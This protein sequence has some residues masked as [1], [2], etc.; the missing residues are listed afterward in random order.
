MGNSVG[1]Q[2]G[3]SILNQI[4][5]SHGGVAAE[6]PAN[7]QVTAANIAELNAVLNAPASYNVPISGG[8][9]S[10]G[11]FIGGYDALQ[12]YGNS[13][14]SKAKEKLIRDIAEEVFNVLKVPGAKNA[15]SAPISDIVAHLKKLSPNPKKGKKFNE[16]F[17]S[18]SSK[19]K[20]VCHA[21]ANAIN[22]NYGGSVI[23][24]NSNEKEMCN[25]VGEVMYSL[26]TG[27]HT[28]FMNVAGDVMRIIRNMRTV[29]DA[30]DAAYRKQIALIQSAGDSQLK[31]QSDNTTSLYKEL[32]DE[33]DRQ[34]AVLAN[35]MNVSIGP[36]GQSLISSLED[37]KDFAGLI[38]DIGAEPG[39][40]A[41]GEKLAHLLSGVSSIAHSAELIDKALKKIGMSVGEFK[42]AKDASEL[43]IKTIGHI[44][45]K[46]PSSKQLDEMMAAA[47][48]IYT[49]NYDHDAVSKLLKGGES[50][51]GG[52][53]ES[54]DEPVQGG[55][56]ED[57]DNNMTPYWSKKSLS[58]KISNKKK[59]RDLVL[60][61][62]RKL[63]RGYYQ[64]VVEAANHI[65][66]KI[67]NEIQLSDDLDNFVKAF[68]NLPTLD[69][70]KIHIALSGYAQDVRSKEKREQF[71]NDYKLVVDC[72]Q[73]L[74]K[75]PAGAS[76][77]EIQL[78]I[79]QMLRAIDD[80]SD[81]MVKAI[82]EIHV[83]RPDQIQ[84]EIKKTATIYGSAEHD[85][86]FGTGSWVAFDKVKME[87]KHFH[88]IADI[89]TNMSRMASEVNDYGVEY[90]Q[91]L[92][93]E[94][95][96]LINNIKSE[97][98]AL[99]DELNLDGD[100]AAALPAL[101]NPSP[102]QIRARAIRTTF[103]TNAAGTTNEQKQASR[104]MLKNILT[105]QMN[106]KV[107]M[108]KV[109]QAVDLYL[110]AVT[111]GL[112]KNPDSV[113][114]VVKLL[115]QVDIVAR[116]FNDK[117]GD[118]L[119]TLFECFPNAADGA[120]R[121]YSADVLTA[122]AKEVKMP[123][124]NQ[125]NHY[126]QDME[127][128]WNAAREN[129]PGNPFIGRK[130]ADTTEA[131]MTSMLNLSEK[132]VK[133]MRALENI[134]SAFSSVGAKLGD[135]N[136]AAMTFMNPGQIFNHLCNYI[137]M[138]AF[139]TQ[140]AP[141]VITKDA[142]NAPVVNDT[143]TAAVY[144]G[145]VDQQ[146]ITVSTDGVAVASTI[147]TTN[148]MA[149]YRQ[150][151]V[152][153]G[154][155][156]LTSSR[157][158]SELQSLH[159]S[160]LTEVGTEHDEEVSFGIIT[161]V[162]NVVN[163]DVNLKTTCI[164]MAAIPAD[165]EYTSSTRTKSNY[166][167]Y[168]DYTNNREVARIDR[169]GWADMFYDTDLLFEMTIKSIVAKV[170]T[171]VDAYR[172]FHRPTVGRSHVYSLNPLR[173]IIGGSEANGGSLSTTVKVVPEALE[174]YF[175]LPLLAEWYREMFG[176]KNNTPNNSDVP[177]LN[178]VNK[179]WKLSIVPSIDG[180]WSEFVNTVFDQAVFVTEG[181]YTESQIQ[182]M[183]EE[184]NKIYKVYKAKY[185][186]ATVRNIINA[187][188]LE[189]NRIF[190]F[191][192][193]EEIKAYLDDKRSYLTQ[194]LGD[195]KEN[196]IDYDILDANDQFG[197]RPAPSDKF[198]NVGLNSRRN[199]ANKER[200]YM[201]QYVH[202]LRTSMD[203]QFMKYT[204]D[205]T[206]TTFS[207]VDTLKN[208]KKDI[209]SARSSEEEYRVV[210]NM[211]QGANKQIHVGY[212]RLIMVHETVAAPLAVLYSIYKVLAKYNALVHS[213]SLNNIDKW[214]NLRQTLGANNPV[215]LGMATTKQ[216]R[217][218][219]RAYL[220]ATYTK[221]I[222]KNQFNLFTLLL[223]GGLPDATPLNPHIGGY[224]N[225]TVGAGVKIT[226]SL[227]SG[228]DILQD[229][230]SA[231]LD[232][233]TTDSN[234]VG[235]SV[236]S[237]GNINIDYSKLQELSVSLLEQVKSNI[238]KLRPLFTG[239]TEAVDKYEDSTTVGST[240]WLEE[241]LVQFLFNNRDEAGLES[242]L[243]NH[244]HKTIEKL[245][246]PPT[247]G[248]VA[249]TDTSY[250][251]MDNAFRGL[252][253][254][255]YLAGAN[256]LVN[257][258]V[259]NNT[260]DFPFNAIAFTKTPE[261]DLEKKTISEAASGS[262]LTAAGGVDIFN[263]LTTVPLIAFETA[264]SINTFN[265]EVNVNKSLMVTLNKLAHMYM[266]T[267]FDNGPAKFYTPLI[268][269]FA[270]SAGSK[271]VIQ[272]KAVPNTTPR[273]DIN[274]THN[275]NNPFAYGNPL[276]SPPEG[277]ILFSSVAATMRSL[278][279]STQLV[280]TVQKKKFAYETLAEVPDYVKDRMKVNLPLFIKMFQNY[281]N[282]AELLKKLLNY[283]GLKN[284]IHSCVTGIVAMPPV[285][286]IAPPGVALPLPAAG[287]TVGLRPFQNGAA[288]NAFYN[289][290]VDHSNVTSARNLVY[291]NGMLDR[292]IEC[293]ASLRKN[294]E[295]VYKELND[296]PPYFLETSK[297][298][299]TD[300][301]QRTGKLPIMP[302]SSLLAVLRVREGVPTAW[303]TV[304]E[305][306]L[307]LPVVENGSDVYKFNYGTRILLA[308]NDIE[309][310][311]EQMPGAKEVY[312]NYASKE[313]TNA[314][315]SMQ[316]YTNTIKNMVKLVRF[317]ADGASY[318]R[319]FDRHDVAAVNAAG[320]QYRTPGIFNA[321][322]WT[323]TT[324]GPV[325]GAN[326]HTSNAAA[327]SAL[328]DAR[329]RDGTN[330]DNYQNLH[331]NLSVFSLRSEGN[332]KATIDLT[333]N[334]SL[335]SNKENFARTLGVLTA[336]TKNNERD[337]LRVYNILDM[338]V[339]PINVHAFM[340]EIP[341]VNILNYAYTFDRMVH[342]FI[343][344]SY[345]ANLTKE[346]TELTTE[347]IMIKADSPVFST[348]EMLV[349]L[350]CHP[351]ADLGTDGRQYFALVASLFNGNDAMKLGRPR[352]LSDQLWHKVFLTS[353][354]QLVANQ[355]VF[356]EGLNRYDTDM[357]SLEAG[358]TAYEAVRAAIRYS[359][360]NMTTNDATYAHQENK[361]ESIADVMLAAGN[362]YVAGNHFHVLSGILF[363]ISSV[364]AAR[365][366]LNANIGTITVAEA[367]VAL[368]SAALGHSFT[369]ATNA[370][371]TPA[372][373]IASL[374][375][376]ATAVAGGAAAAGLGLTLEQAGAIIDY[377]TAVNAHA[378]IV[379]DIRNTITTDVA[380]P[381]A[382]SAQLN[383]VLAADSK[384]HEDT[385]QLV[386][387]ILSNTAINGVAI[388][389]ASQKIINTIMP[390]YAENNKITG[391]AAGLGGRASKG[392]FHER[393]DE[394]TESLEGTK[395]LSLALV[396]LSTTTN[397][398][399]AGPPSAAAIAVVAATNTAKNVAAIAG[400]GS[401]VSN[402]ILALALDPAVVAVPNNYFKNSGSVFAGGKLYRNLKNELTRAV[403]HQLT[404]AA[405]VLAA[406]GRLAYGNADRNAQVNK[407]VDSAIQHL[408]STPASTA[409]QLEAA[410][411]RVNIPGAPAE[412]IADINNCAT[413]A[414][415]TA[416]EVARANMY[417][418]TVNR[419]IEEFAR[420]TGL[421]SDISDGKAQASFKESLL[422]ALSSGVYYDPMVTQPAEDGAANGTAG[423]L[424]EFK[425]AIVTP[426]EGLLAA[427]SEASLRSP[428]S[429]HDVNNR[430]AQLML[431]SRTNATNTIAAL[432]FDRPGKNGIAAYISGMIRLYTSTTKSL[433]GNLENLNKSTEFKVLRK[434]APLNI[435]SGPVSTMGLKY[436]D[437]NNKTWSVRAGGAANMD[438]GDVLYC[439]ELGKMRFDTKLVRNLTWLVQLQR[440]MRVVLINHLSWINTPVIRG[441][442]IADPKVTEYAG[443]DQFDEKD[444]TGEN[445]SMF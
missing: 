96:W 344:P 217:D 138:S 19:Q 413:V 26:F 136:P 436:W 399:L 308:R 15:R 65:S 51:R 36:T 188:I 269:T 151:S 212:D 10:G 109:A 44:M 56:D 207:F 387:R 156:G 421:N 408:T 433:A 265:I 12:D 134:L 35:L 9:V 146:R 425:N 178:S 345:I 209:A 304:D 227:V 383:A 401:E 245:S 153:G 86:T 271:E 202:Q 84:A 277:S 94:S 49:N 229:I 366:A 294:A 322:Q 25:Q 377:N 118:N 11:S 162:S 427:H 123:P 181:N 110:K 106:A 1:S 220:E 236:G 117:S 246:V 360:T 411:A 228:V 328:P 352:Y 122:E 80:F 420:V 219:Y 20:E 426:N 356:R 163:A 396:A 140:F 169:A 422:L 440:I 92:G 382:V 282:R 232:L 397:G 370:I 390:A 243:T 27:L 306:H 222:D 429:T 273:I 218:V 398:A 69:E 423:S 337:K 261:T 40:S 394:I 443:N 73:P 428:I 354:A 143:I 239:N 93:E 367:P 332:L 255:R 348:R 323:H 131:G 128:K 419:L 335:D 338:N 28:E 184:M 127:S 307:L 257:N 66:H 176:I 166:W 90:E 329:K 187:Y 174:L 77:K 5:L 182:R 327:L 235:C 61:D 434:N 424:G 358:P 415:T 363:A 290:L 309:P 244:L 116:W 295:A 59:Y 437:H 206:D 103:T 371:N 305:S 192:K 376:D 191:L 21:L 435:P 410:M 208:Y 97:Y 407:W 317:L 254:Y 3:G 272:G 173:T 33:Y 102:L 250:G 83:D 147:P 234:L 99:I 216:L 318:G 154:L 172:L 362:A 346:G 183:I 302:A 368:I 120:N 148:Q 108:V 242:A 58:K 38:K 373:I 17:N 324:I 287:G 160:G 101:A 293:S 18:S 55:D 412:V 205:D 230:L 159:L 379:Q 89:K 201:Q 313:G 57:F 82:T 315:V 157:R 384:S 319:L 195:D 63:L 260:R 167:K 76:F 296:K 144:K 361:N 439:A 388:P 442:K 350:L 189:M 23:N 107:N 403:Q 193:T 34:S 42:N 341:F 30:L 262:T 340:R 199:K 378:T 71:I 343:L 60:K 85:D 416:S 339:V 164:A 252:I 98:I 4:Y 78:V 357:R 330:R 198:I 303:K 150:A 342:E 380:L 67:G 137:K 274:P 53:D 210:L 268:E 275:G 417:L 364:P 213:T 104:K 395:H 333:E 46:E 186:K 284:N 414:F 39:T 124:L 100:I 331:Q 214:N 281:Y 369:D 31:Q 215:G 221:V 353:S 175:R 121:T 125:N 190:G 203:V 280:Q 248:M 444:Y 316:E 50:R 161:G 247:G 299:I 263:S 177:T 211:I 264:A 326:T 392:R 349:K 288:G 320:V 8:S 74:L 355:N 381:L 438:I 391:T 375:T 270:N 75:G 240:R 279:Q 238:K 386:M 258:F 289:A 130:L 334:T 256:S 132:V 310:Q 88:S 91:L 14:F 276:A 111:N 179:E 43:R 52:G 402:A 393:F 48:I 145:R 418:Y 301:K 29:Q 237:S 297:D 196:F 285:P 445:Y 24:M 133:S 400:V 325:A 233:T 223:S 405:G 2:A 365:I 87:M 112:G 41:F 372:N 95:G 158:L 249:P 72:V 359:S 68:S 226:P 291:L 385:Y 278:L 142:N 321:V 113:S 225:N 351:W 231:I 126:Y 170:F 37:N 135:V 171:I 374:I 431:I 409:V 432:L 404:T 185:P 141:N 114:S 336:E 6:K 430:F 155:N 283:T 180:V 45:K 241:N 115:D 22:S 105:E 168:H 311:L 64:R 389:D 406:G 197:D 129:L 224:I 300:Y 286:P 259:S 266:Y 16:S 139:T 81:K 347:N 62:F 314:V 47:Q 149:N 152:I 312:N 7:L 54:D 298:F 119:A 13:L 32:K 251:T 253:Y 292:A 79:S 441:L 165:G 70:E 194:T 267:N 200:M 204:K